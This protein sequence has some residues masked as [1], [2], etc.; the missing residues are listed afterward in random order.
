MAHAGAVSGDRQ[1]RDRRA[2]GCARARRPR[3][4]RCRSV[5]AG[6]WAD[7][8]ERAGTAV[9]AR[10]RGGEHPDWQGT[11]HRRGDRVAGADDRAA[12]VARARSARAHRARACRHVRRDSRPRAE[13]AEWGL[14]AGFGDVRRAMRWAG[15][16]RRRARSCLVRRSLESGRFTV[17]MAR[18]PADQKSAAPGG[19]PSERALSQGSDG[20][21]RTCIG[22]PAEC[23]GK[24]CL[25]NVHRRLIA[26]RLPSWRRVSLRRAQ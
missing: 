18:M 4:C 22:R 12:A 8:A 17:E 1:P 20:I 14:T 25:R 7:N 3:V 24:R 26:L 11:G 21:E 5:R 2:V 6:H 16:R 9:G 19:E 10:V 15:S 13:A 23:V